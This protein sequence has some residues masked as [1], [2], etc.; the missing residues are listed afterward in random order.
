MRRAPQHRA[1]LAIPFGIIGVAGA[2]MVSD[3]YGIGVDYGDGQARG[4]LMFLTPL[5]AL[6]LGGA[7]SLRWVREHLLRTLMVTALGTGLAGVAIGVAATWLRFPHSELRY[8]RDVGALVGLQTGLA[9][10]PL[11]LTVALLGRRVGRARA[12]SII[13]DL[14]VRRIFG[15]V[16]FAI[17]GG[18]PFVALTGERSSRFSVDTTSALGV[19]ATVVLFAFASFDVLSYIRVRRATRDVIDMRR[20]EPESV[21]VEDVSD[22]GIGD[23][24]YEQ[25]AEVGSAYRTNHRPLRAIIGEPAAAAD[26]LRGALA[27]SAIMLAL[28]IGAS[29]LTL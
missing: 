3:F 1:Q 15:V 18:A 24:A 19:V 23:E 28:A 29:A 5:V 9:F 10:L 14:D 17:A 7:L 2:L 21:F 12:G 22:M 13:D 26:A 6:V 8:A 25:L 11:V 16:A 27:Q 20:T 4:A